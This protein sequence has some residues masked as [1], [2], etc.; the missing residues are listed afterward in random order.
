MSRRS[1]QDTGPA[2]RIFDVLD[3]NNFLYVSSFH[4][5]RS[6]FFLQ[7]VRVPILQPTVIFSMDFSDEFCR[8]FGN[9]AFSAL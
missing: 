5:F 2:L 8:K 1:K 7:I 4:N 6:L 3:G 9:V